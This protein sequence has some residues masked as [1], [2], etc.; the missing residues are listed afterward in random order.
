MSDDLTKPCPLCGCYRQLREPETSH[1]EALQ[2]E[3]KRLR[4]AFGLV[5]IGGNHLAIHLPDCSPAFGAPH[6]Q[7]LEAMGPGIYYDIWCC[8][9]SIMVAR[10]ALSATK[11]DAEPLEMT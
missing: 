9:N 1:T 10:A 6:L 8:W 7:A 3:N 4:E 2:D 5:M 11:P